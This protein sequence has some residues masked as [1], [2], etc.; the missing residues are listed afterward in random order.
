MPKRHPLVES[1]QVCPLLLSLFA[2]CPGL[3]PTAPACANRPMLPL[4]LCPMPSAPCPLPHALTREPI[5][6]CPTLWSTKQ[7]T[8]LPTTLVADGTCLHVVNIVVH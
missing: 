5:C 2:L 7:S 1:R 6:D 8:T 4:A 3:L